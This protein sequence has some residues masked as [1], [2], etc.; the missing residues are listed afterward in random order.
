MDNS[1]ANLTS[2]I[3]NYN[4]REQ[5][6]IMIMNTL[7]FYKDNERSFHNDKSY[8]KH[9]SN[10]DIKN[11]IGR[12]F[13][14]DIEIPDIEDKFIGHIKEYIHPSFHSLVDSKDLHTIAQLH[15]LNEYW[16][17]NK[18][19]IIG[20]QY[21]IFRYGFNPNELMTILQVYKR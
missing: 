1:A 16:N 13:R 3:G 7:L 6:I 17:G 2:V 12:F 9:P 4:I 18:I 10:P 11:A 20:L 5:I 19:S 14:D 8:Y 15:D 21:L